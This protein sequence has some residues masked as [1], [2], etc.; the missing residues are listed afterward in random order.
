MKKILFCASVLALAASCTESELDSLSVKDGAIKGLGFGVELA[1]TPATRGDLADEN[2]NGE[3]KFFWYAEQDRISIWSTRTTEDVGSENN[4]NSNANFEITKKAVYKATKS[5]VN[6]DFTAINDE[7]WIKFNGST[8]ENP[9]EFIAVYPSTVQVKN[10]TGNKADGYAVRISGFEAIGNQ[11]TNKLNAN[12]VADIMP[13]ISYSTAYPTNSYDGVGEKIKLQ[14]LRPF[15]LAK[16]KTV[17]VTE[18]NSLFGKLKQITLT[19]KGYDKNGNNLY[20]DEG[21]IQSSI[22]AYNPDAVDYVYHTKDNSKSK[23]VDKTTGGTP[24]TIGT[25]QIVLT[26]NSGSGLKWTDDDFAY[27]AINRI[28]RTAAGFTAE[29]P[30]KMSAKYEFENITF[31]VEWTT[32]NNWPKEEGVNRINGMKVLDMADYAYLVTN[33]GVNGRALIVNSGNFAGAF[34]DAKDKIVWNGTDIDFSEF[35]TIISKVALTDGELALLKNFTDLKSIELAENTKIPANTFKDLTAIKKIVMP[36]VSE[37]EAG[38]FASNVA[39]EEVILPSYKFETKAISN[40]LL[41]AGSLGKLDMSAVETMKNVF[42][43]EGFALTN[44]AKL[45]SVKVKDGVKVGSAAFKGCV[46]LTKIDGQVDVSEGPNAFEGSAITEITLT[47][48]DIPAGT[49]KDC[50][51]LVKVLDKDGANIQPTKVGNAAFA[52]C[53]QLRYMDL[54]QVQGEGS[55]IGQEAFKNCTS[56]VGTSRGSINVLT[57]GAETISASAFAGCKALKYVEFTGATKIADNILAKDDSNNVILKELKFKQVLVSKVGSAGMFGN[58]SN[59]KLFLNPE[60]PLSYYE[61]NKFYPKG[62]KGAAPVITFNSIIL[63]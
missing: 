60:Q 21:D 17:G 27:M 11:N 7:N 5:E 15:G 9:S 45:T 36:K 32:V 31:N 50:D 6:G 47:N 12:A 16:F 18:Y 58:A 4:A 14:M 38:A 39:L 44:F 48:T 49:F 35:T 55:V 10:I 42:P 43:A 46:L 23:F 28:N 57:V 1:E 54:S 3:Q 13:M 61:G 59:T 8:E 22:L 33:N 40:V 56:L 62:N 19:A 20:T 29:K 26:F 2:E 51:K 25:S 37:I 52:G 34:N 24:S 63:E 30:E 53:K 41:K